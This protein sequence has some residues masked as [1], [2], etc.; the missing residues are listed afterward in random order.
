M[1]KKKIPE[2]RAEDF[3]SCDFPANKTRA[4]EKYESKDEKACREIP[5]TILYFFS[6]SFSMGKMIDS[7]FSAICDFEKVDQRCEIPFVDESRKSNAN[8]YDMNRYF[9]AS[10][11]CNGC[12]HEVK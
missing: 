7:R 6:C 2:S 5:V 11:N 4:F 10:R 8:K 12:K 3:D 9:D 1:G